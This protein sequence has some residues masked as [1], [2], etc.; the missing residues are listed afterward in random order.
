MSF[1]RNIPK[2]FPPHSIVLVRVDFNV[3]I[4]AQGKIIDS[5]R[6]L[7]HL[8]TIRFLKR[9]DCK[10]VLIS[11]LGKPNGHYH[12]E[13]SF[14][15]LLSQLESLLQEKIDLQSLET[16]Q[17]QQQISLIDNVRFY[18]GEESNDDEFSKRLANLGTIYIN[19]AFS[20][21]HRAHASTVGLTRYLP[22]YAGVALQK[23]FNA[24]FSVMHHPHSP[25]TLVIGGKKLTD[26][27][28]VLE[29]LLPKV[30]QVLIGGA[31]ANAF[32]RAQGKDIGQSYFEVNMVQT[33]E[34]LLIKYPDKIVLPK[35]FAKLNNCNLDIGPETIQYY[36]KLLVN[37]K[38]VIWAG[39]M[40]KYEED[41]FNRGT[42]ALLSAIARPGIIS[43]IGGGD[44]IAALKDAI[45]LNHVT[46]VSLGG[47]A[48][49]EFLAKEHLP[50]TDCLLN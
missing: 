47:G 29:H 2:H 17:A 45:G 43:I 46:L 11:H 31:C 19:D 22:S 39:P 44:T 6:I 15:P 10:I 26:K 21:S 34:E 36:Q 38:S 24:L 33:C 9:F 12:P 32:W 48:M 37:S 3:P 16:F 50:G 1:L 8:P 40:G 23:E 35:D 13:L 25:I 7:N 18:P 27:I 30:D 28:G 14:K 4:D 5:S 49:L 20:V 41:P 42:T